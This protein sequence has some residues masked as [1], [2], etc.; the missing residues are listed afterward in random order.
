MI[1]DAVIERDLGVFR[2]ADAAQAEI[3]IT[4]SFFPCSRRVR[5]SR[6]HLE[7]HAPGRAAASAGGDVALGE[8]ALAT[9]VMGGVDGETERR[10]AAFDRALDA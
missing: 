5:Q 4:H 10:I 9:A 1:L 3:L 2:G 6:R 7:V 8:I